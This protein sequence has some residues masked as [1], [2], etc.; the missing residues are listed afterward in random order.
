MTRSA[1]PALGA[2]L[3]LSLALPGSALAAPISVTTTDD[4]ISSD[5]N[6]SLRE[7]VFAANDNST[8]TGGDC[9]LGSGDDVITLGFGTYD[10]ELANVSPPGENSN[11]TGDLDVTSNL[12]IQGQG[13]NQ[14]T[15][16]ANSLDRVLHM[17]G[18]STV[19]E[20]RDL[21][22]TGGAAPSGDEGAPGADTATNVPSVGGV[23][24]AGAA[25]GGIIV[26]GGDLT[27]TSVEVSNNSAGSGGDGGIGGVA[28]NGTGGNSGASSTGGIGGTGGSGGGV[29]L[30]AGTQLHATDSVFDGN[31]AGDGGD[32]GTGGTG[33]VGDSVGANGG[34]SIG[35]QG[36][37]GGDGGAI[38]AD[39]A[40]VEL[41]RVTM[42]ANQAGGS[43]R[44]GNGGTG[45]AGGTNI[46]PAGGRGGTS[47]GGSAVFGGFGGAISQLNTTVTV[48][49]SSLAGNKAGA[50]GDGGLAGTPGV[51]GVGARVRTGGH[52]NGGA[53]GPGGAYGAISGTDGGVTLVGSTV[54]GNALGRG[55]RRRQR[56]CGRRG[57]ISTGGAGGGG[58][59]TGGVFEGSG[60]GLTI[61]NSTIS[62]NAAG[63]G[64]AGGSGSGAGSI[65]G[66]GGNGGGQAGVSAGAVVGGVLNHVTI[67]G[68]FAG[69]GAPGGAGATPGADGS[70]GTVGGFHSDGNNIVLRNS[71]IASNT[72]NQCS[73]SGFIDGGHN[74]SFPPDSPVNSCPATL[75]SN[76]L[77]DVLAGNGGA[78]QTM[79]LG[80]GSPAI[81]AVPASGAFCEA[82]DQRDIDRPR[83]LGGACDIGA[84][85][86]ARP[87]VTTGAFSAL[88]S[89]SANVAGTVNPNQRPTT[90]RFAFGKTTAYG[91][92]TP[93]VAAAAGDSAAPVA[94]A[95]TGLT[96][97]TLYHY[98][99]TATNGDGTVVGA[100][101]TFT[102]PAAPK[103]AT[104]TTPPGTLPSFGG[105]SI[106]TK[107]A[108]ADRKGR[109]SVKLRCP[110]SAV[111]RCKGK[112]SL[113]AKVKK[114]TVKLGKASFSIAPGKTKTV[115]IKLSKSKRRL[116]ARSKRLK[117]SLSAAATDNRGGK[118]KT[119]KGKLGVKAPK[120]KR[121]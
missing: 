78:T 76:P 60:G 68:N 89:T 98:R 121:T 91:S 40:L 80:V 111:T 70:D 92:L 38:S 82:I 63:L 94:A 46:G 39:A 28:G 11:A 2:L 101:K 99:V 58:G 118:A 13:V 15:I 81:D 103:P 57:A 62:G 84:F 22:I 97:S 9:D 37:F 85:E 7:A 32:G 75:H 55:R 114:K 104:P 43:G 25:G 116:L 113:T 107:S 71:I 30:A 42:T 16:D 41:D 19:V 52:R 96:P 74:I 67:A 18:I 45:G 51:G 49:D 100:D 73:G 106:L 12:T 21:K 1:R 83:P 77:L 36:G 120:R 61:T 27:L 48:T 31:F 86:S 10:L 65:G 88:T 69:G 112:L 50:A 24:D 72:A 64:G 54:S 53:G 33:G 34:D 66:Q 110:A 95:L 5:T 47:T 117:G 23:G 56:R 93:V 90:Y 14:T 3:L 109:V 79:A 108:R 115:R 87:L 4:V 17:I 59:F 8:G 6:C 20:L 105:V 102:T 29:S 35:G 119:T 44:G 26:Q